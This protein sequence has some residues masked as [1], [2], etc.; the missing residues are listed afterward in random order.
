MSTL[1][2]TIIDAEP[3]PEARSAPRHRALLERLR[4]MAPHRQFV[5]LGVITVVAF[6]LV[7][8]MAIAQ[9]T[10]AHSQAE[11]SQDRYG[12][13]I[14][15]LERAA[16]LS[17]R[18]EAAAQGSIDPTTGAVLPDVAEVARISGLFEQAWDQYQS[19]AAG[20]PGEQAIQG[21]VDRL[22]DDL[23]GTGSIAL[24]IPTATE[25]Q[26][27]I[28]LFEEQATAVRSIESRYVAALQ[29]SV[30]V[31]N[32][33][34]DSALSVLWV[35][36]GI[37]GVAVL[38]LFGL[39]VHASR[40]WGREEAVKDRE[41]AA[42]THRDELESRLQRALEMVHTEDA[43]YGLV[44][45]A[46]RR[47]APGVPAELLLADSSRAHFHQVATTTGTAEAPGCG[48]SAPFECPAA[49]RGQT[50]VFADSAELDACPYLR[51][52]TSGP[53]VGG[54]SAV[55]VPVSIAG[56]TVG[57]VH[58]IGS[59]RDLMDRDQIAAIE[60]VARKSGER[61]GMMRAFARSETQARTDPLTG[62]LNRRS[63]ETQTREL[64]DEARSY[65]V[66]Y[67]DLDHFKKLNDVYGHEAGDRALRLFARV[68]RDAVRP[69]DIPARYGGEEFVVVLPD[70]NTSDAFTVLERIR[71]SLAQ[72][73]GEGSVPPFTV[74]FGLAAA[75]TG[76]TF[77]EALDAAD[78]ALLAAK[79]AGRDRVVVSDPNKTSLTDDELAGMLEA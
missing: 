40:V 57:V 54:C 38:T 24:Q 56:K 36:A 20:L 11:R 21:S 39:V 22:H 16:T 71:H 10:A 77:G 5:A 65:V 69:A 49:V 62:L 52:R 2:S 76:W 61:I 59:A 4:H 15:A 78:T 74:S 63:L 12:P 70:C 58:A 35:I 47:T 9:M 25:L 67:G 19:K 75:E 14:A 43:S 60:L 6:G 66:A 55:C 79:A 64:T 31:H 51:N 27:T 41:R 46:L 68:L 1:E 42:Q 53:A 17:E 23:V 13:A 30:R 44:A 8:G 29:K 3:L 48:V 34:L 45:E 7:A 18:A 72:A 28:A 33:T 32:A 37:V 26:R 73:L 50:Q